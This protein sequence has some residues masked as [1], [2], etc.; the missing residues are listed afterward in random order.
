M[1]QHRDYDIY[2]GKRME[3]SLDYTGDMEL[4]YVIDGEV[5]IA[6][7]QKETVLA[8]M[9]IYI[10]NPG[11]DR[12]VRFQRNGILCAVRFSRRFL[13]ELNQYTCP[14]FKVSAEKTEAYQ[15]LVHYLQELCYVHMLHAK[16]TD[17]QK[18]SILYKILDNLMEHFYIEDNEI[19]GRFEDEKMERIISFVYENI[20]EHI[21][22]DDLAEELYV[23]KSTLSRM[24]K[25][26]MGIYFADYV[27]EIRLQNALSEIAYT[28][29]SITRIALDSGFSNASALNRIFKEKMGQSPREYRENKLEELENERRIA[30]NDEEQIRRK[31]EETGVEDYTKQLMKTEV[32]V[33]VNRTLKFQNIW[34]RA[35]NMGS[36]YDMTLSNL[37]F[38]ALYL[39]ENLGFSC[40]RMWNV[41][42]MKLRFTDGVSTGNY[43]YDAMDSV[44]DFLVNNHLRA[45]L[46]FGRRPN[47]AVR[48]PG[49][50]VFYEDEYIEFAS[51]KAWEA[52]V[53][54]I[55]RHL[56][57]RYGKEEI[58]SW[59]FELSR[60][61]FHPESF[62]YQTNQP[63]YREEFFFFYKT[64][65]RYIPDAMVGGPSNVFE[66]ASLEGYRDFIHACRKHEVSPDF[67][68]FM[69]FPY[70]QSE[71]PEERYA[72]K[73]VDK[74]VVRYLEELRNLLEKEGEGSCRIF[75]SECNST[76]SNRNYLN[77]SCYRGIYYIQ[78]VQELYGKADL[79]CAWVGSDW[80]SSY[81]DTRSVVY[82]AAGFLTK[83]MIKKPVYHAISFLNQMGGELLAS[84]DGYLAARNGERSF[85]ILCYYGKPLPAQ[86]FIENE[87]EMDVSQLDRFFLGEP[88]EM[89]I[90]LKGVPDPVPEGSGYV[91]KRSRINRK[92]GGILAEWARFGYEDELKR[93]D[94]KY[95][96][97]VSIPYQERQHVQIEDGKL[98]ISLTVAVQEMILIQIVDEE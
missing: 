20:Q 65:K 16:K 29:K 55:L 23:S 24:F 2:I 77:D 5:T 18:C 62:Y 41:F 51:K 33:D 90:T 60:D 78:M 48:T 72:R 26:N 54:D 14:F 98:R 6:E 13:V 31:V 87:K 64:V 91:M 93:E 8:A 38:H 1:R 49:K 12:S 25:K 89:V 17:A 63:D 21:S 57:R 76:L 88:L 97:D 45:W 94:I 69:Y 39:A 36:L 19:T 30:Q 96:R 92:R 84:G 9:D 32:S 70:A 75:I 34:G 10:K 61:S 85:S 15:E 56:Q 58:S 3:L 47:T 28:D 82:G 73:P 86:Y 83:D 52:A 74:E 22:L 50:T 11:F 68:S 42:S 67:Y 7:E 4:F 27:N 80:L 95:I 46:D 35:I 81:F 53:S 40:F 59:I 44:F 37:Q 66:H 79:L 71:K 43:N